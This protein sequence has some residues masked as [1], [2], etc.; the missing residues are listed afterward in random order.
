[1]LITT[2]TGLVQL[3]ERSTAEREVTGTIPGTKSILRV[4]EKL[5]RN[6]QDLRMA[7]M[8]NG[9]PVPNWYFLA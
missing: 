2:A 3:V 5:R 4:L 9:G 1:M 7:R 6:R 8:T